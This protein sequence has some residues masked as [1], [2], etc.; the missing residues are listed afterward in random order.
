MEEPT[1][2]ILSDISFKTF[3]ASF[4]KLKE[5]AATSGH[6]ILATTNE[7]KEAWRSENQDWF[8]KIIGDDI[9]NCDRF[10]D[11]LS[12]ER[13][14]SE[15]YYN[16]KELSSREQLLA[17]ALSLFDETYGDQFFAALEHLVENI[18]K[19]RDP[20]LRALDYCD[21]DKLLAFFSFSGRNEQE[22]TIKV[23][24]SRQRQLLLKVAWSSHRR[25]ILS[26]LPILVDLAKSSIEGNSLELYGSAERRAR[27]RQTISE[28]ISNIGLISQESKVFEEQ[29]L[30][31]ASDKHIEVQAVAATALAVWRNSDKKELIQLDSNSNANGNN[32]TRYNPDQKLF[33]IIT[34]WQEQTQIVN[35]VDSFLRSKNYNLGEKPV[36]YIRATIALTVGLA[37][38]TDPYD[39]M[40]E[41]LL[42][43]LRKLVID[44]SKLVRDRVFFDALPRI[45]RR[46]T[47]QVQSELE[48][49]LIDAD[50]EL[51][52]A[53]SKSLSE[54]YKFRPD[55]VLDILESWKEKSQVTESS[56]I[57][58]GQK[59]IREALRSTVALTYGELNTESIERIIN[60]LK[61]ILSDEKHPFVRSLAIVA[62]GMQSQKYFDDFQII[63]PK[64]KGLVSEITQEERNEIAN[65]LTNIYLKQR[66]S[67]TGGDRVIEIQGKQYS[68]W[69]DSQ[70]PLTTVEQAMI[71]WAKD[72]SNI[73]AQ[74]VATQASV[75]FVD[76]FDKEEAEKIEQL[77][78]E[79]EN[80]TIET[81]EEYPQVIK[82]VQPPEDWYMGK[83]I[84]W[85]VTR[86][87]ENSGDF[88]NNRTSIRNIL[89]ESLF[90]YKKNRESMNFV[91][92]KWKNTSD[93]RIQNIADRLKSGIFWAQNMKL[94][95]F[96]VLLIIVNL[97][98]TS[99]NQF[100]KLPPT[101]NAK[102]ITQPSS[103][104]SSTSPTPSQSPTTS[105]LQDNTNATVV[106]DR[107]DYYKNV[108][109]GI[110]TN[111]PVL[112]ELPIGSRVQIIG[113]RYDADG[114]P[115][116]KIYS[117]QKRR[118]GWIAGQ[119]IERD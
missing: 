85:F 17:I 28:S 73:S 39:R 53:I 50:I 60:Y 26:A 16:E 61:S 23:T 36:N 96:G 74:Q 107:K 33:N 83:L 2:F 62:I 41:E 70:R 6:Y 10:I 32:N 89:P 43:L 44:T 114:F 66:A 72:D 93:K 91:L 47:R 119:L 4:E 31:L 8:C 97:V 111:S 90:H 14:I 110:T 13:L 40:S 101:N 1:V 112:F 79:I 94:V 118:E 115:W 15:W 9:E 77:R 98:N 3:G 104:S 69:L 65:I 100:K 59:T 27:I 48:D 87:F 75:N 21:L 55:A 12:D 103:S 102:E 52:V 20:T 42:E 54:A 24:S 105:K 18:W 76:K 58:K 84:P 45:V 35:L 71:D 95:M 38:E 7:S 92:E 82:G 25:Q 46:H 109:A 56:K 86:D 22:E 106:G 117:P 34:R 78:E 108:R 57:A 116:Y 113:S 80:S 64:L 51:I 81:L 88:E 67:L 68:V 29:L 30:S 19:R 99:I 37:S 63:A 11:K 49:F 5:S